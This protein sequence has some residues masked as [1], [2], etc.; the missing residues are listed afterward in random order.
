M[1]VL[2]RSE[3]RGKPAGRPARD[4]RP[5]RHRRLSPPAQ[6]RS[7]RR[8]PRR[9]ER[10]QRA[11]RD[12]RLA[13]S[14]AEDP[15]SRR[16]RRRPT[17]ARRGSA[18]PRRRRLERADGRAALRQPSAE[19]SSR[20]ASSARA[21]LRGRTP[22]AERARTALAARSADGA[23][24]RRRARTRGRVAEGVVELLGNGSAFLRVT[25]PSPPTTTST[26]PPPRCA[27]ASSSPATASAGRCARRGAPSATRR[28]CASTRSTARRRRRSPTA[29]ATTTCRRLPERAPRARLRRPDAG[30][31]RVADA[32]RPRLAR[33]DRRRRARRQ[34]ARPCGAC[35]SA[36]AG[37]EGLEVTL[38]L[39]GVRPE[40][41]ARVAGGPGAPAA[42][43]SFAASADSQGQ[44]VERAIETAKRVAARG[45]DARG[46]DRQPRRAAPARGAQGARGGAQPRDGGSLTVIATATAPARRRDDGD[47][48][49]RAL[50]VDRPPADPRPRRAA[51][52]SSRSCS[53]ARTAPRRSPSARRPRWRPPASRRRRAAGASA[54]ALAPVGDAAPGGLGRQLDRLAAS[55]SGC[56]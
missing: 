1:A 24:A 33:G 28:W 44:A 36:L 7:D 27:A 13:P 38:V 34:D 29:R 16:Q 56:T 2:E 39:A 45:G 21:S 52:R 43:L 11:G 20:D 4:R 51:A 10:P 14:P 32:A 25:R 40:E 12:G 18:R 46:A 17:K 49:R 35:W 48:A 31:D 30:G 47:R 23:R 3:L 42:A 41:I 54:L 5:A 9:A 53:S 19:T 6:G 26:S 22:R 15:S 55:R 8:D 37:Q 50:T